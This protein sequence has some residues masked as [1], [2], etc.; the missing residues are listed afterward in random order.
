MDPTTAPGPDPALN[1]GQASAQTQVTSDTLPETSFAAQSPKTSLGGAVSDQSTIPFPPPASPKSDQQA[2]L[3]FVSQTV[4]QTLKSTAP[5]MPA[6]RSD[7]LLT[8][9]PHTQVPVQSQLGNSPQQ[10][11]LQSQAQED[12][13]AAVAMPVV[14][15]AAA[16]TLIEPETPVG[17]AADKE[18]VGGSALKSEYLQVPDVGEVK[19]VE[20][21]IEKWLEEKEQAGEIKIPEAIKDEHG[22]VVLDNA[23][24]S[25]VHDQVVV[26][27][28][29]QA[30]V[31]NK[32]QPIDS[33]AKWL[34][35]WVER[36]AKMF[37]GR[38]KFKEG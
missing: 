2:V 24:A 5:P 20:P 26:P 14:Q 36:I 30:M 37:E 31:A 27:M 6:A 17:S 33:A 29:H 11:N 25:I 7:S 8:S 19:E 4:P 28:S 18:R 3:S 12:V 10:T 23:P 35:Y 1:A 21:D 22:A 34:A 38:V 16:Q 13:A 9:I 15:A 32:K